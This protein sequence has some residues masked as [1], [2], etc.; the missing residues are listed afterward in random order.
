MT[1][2]AASLGHN[3]VSS[4][5]DNW[6]CGSDGDRVGDGKNSRSGCTWD[7]RGDTDGTQEALSGSSRGSG[8]DNAGD[9]G[10]REI[11]AQA[12]GADVGLPHGCIPGYVSGQSLGIVEVNPH[13]KYAGVTKARAASSTLLGSA[14]RFMTAIVEP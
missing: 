11:Q 3:G 4:L 13:L 8:S 2:R 14:S 12:G 5:E 1:G 7:S 10:S 9:L 6:R